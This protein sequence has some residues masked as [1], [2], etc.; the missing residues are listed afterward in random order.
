V[1]PSEGSLSDPSGLA[2]AGAVL[3]TTAGDLRGY[4]SAPEESSVLVEVVAA[5]GVQASWAISRAA[6][7][8][9][10]LRD[11]IDERHEL[12]DIVPV[13]AGQ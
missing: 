9:T 12:G 10:N 2:Q 6:T 4:P 8:A 13:A 7:Q 11:G 5:V 1:K 3:G